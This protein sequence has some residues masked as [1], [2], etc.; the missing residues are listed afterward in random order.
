MYFGKNMSFLKV[1]LKTDSIAVFSAFF[2]H[3]TACCKIDFRRFW[4][5][6]RNDRYNIKNSFKLSFSALGN[7]KK[8][9]R[10]MFESCLE[11]ISK[12]ILIGKSM[13]G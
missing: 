8:R 2:S 7:V 13:A 1:W 3:R 11:H 9:F 4:E 12:L 10:R 6:N 5:N